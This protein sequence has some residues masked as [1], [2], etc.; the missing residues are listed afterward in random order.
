[1][2]ITSVG[3]KG[4]HTKTYTATAYMAEGSYTVNLVNSHKPWTYTVAPPVPTY[5]TVPVGV[6]AEYGTEILFTA[7]PDPGTYTVTAN[8]GSITYYYVATK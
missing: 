7:S 4:L 1:M 2:T 3:K 6:P 8:S 5:V